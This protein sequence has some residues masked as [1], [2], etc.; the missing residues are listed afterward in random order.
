M[1]AFVAHGIGRNKIFSERTSTRV[2]LRPQG[3]G[4]QRWTV[5][6]SPIRSSTGYGA[7]QNG[8]ARLERHCGPP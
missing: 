1:D 5:H 2:Q 4:L 6:R 8:I 7:V 3:Q